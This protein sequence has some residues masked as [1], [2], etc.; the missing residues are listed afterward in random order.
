MFPFA[1]AS[2]AQMMQLGLR[3]SVM[4]AEAQA[5]MAMRLFGM[6]GLWPVAPQEN[7]RMVTEKIAAMHESQ[8]AAF[9]A[10]MKGASAAGVAEAA[11]RPVRRRTRANAGRLAKRSG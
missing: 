5:V 1:P 7:S 2:A 10:V 4:L 6:F 8:A 3:S 9:R 11:L